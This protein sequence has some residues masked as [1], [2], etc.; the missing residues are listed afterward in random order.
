MGLVRKI[1]GPASKYEGTLP[2]AYAAR[3]RAVEGEGG[4]EEQY[5]SETVCALI[6]RLDA[7]G[8]S[9]EESSL[10]GVYR[11]VEIPL[12][13]AH[14]ISQEGKW[15]KRPELCRSLEEHYRQSMELQY[16]GHTEHS[17]CSFDDREGKVL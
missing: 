10:F 17:R 2:Y 13:L 1:L 6:E 11:D 14:C 12:D 4:I 8:I 5:Y 7:L 15:L 9:P 3:V 16:K